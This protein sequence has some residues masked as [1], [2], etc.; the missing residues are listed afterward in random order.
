MDLISILTTVILTTTIGTVIVGFVAYGAFK[1]R[2]KRKPK[3]KAKNAENSA[4]GGEIE[5]IFLT[6]YVPASSVT[7]GQESVPH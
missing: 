4:A 6:P 2:D 3:A 1:L 7:A 5:A